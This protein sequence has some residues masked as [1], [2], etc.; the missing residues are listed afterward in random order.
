VQIYGTP[1]STPQVTGFSATPIPFLRDIPFI[2][3]ALFGQS[4]FVWVAVLLAIAIWFLLSRTTIGLRIRA[5]GEQPQVLEASGIAV[6]PVRYITIA[7]SGVL[8]G[9]GGA[10]L[11]LSMLNNFSENMTA[12]RGFIALAA[13]IF[14]GWKA[15][16]VLG[17][18]LFFGFAT[19]MII[20]VPQDVLD[21]QLLH[22]VPYVVTIIALVMFGRGSTAPAS[23]GVPYRPGAQHS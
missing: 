3:P 11:S 20:R 19:A 16:R 23:V 18:A 10:Y 7:V 13:V 8:C 21:P 9:L 4:W 1:G 22:I 2:G 17:A 5:S 6:L 12:G 15:P 14:G